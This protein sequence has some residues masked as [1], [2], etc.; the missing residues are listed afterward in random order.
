MLKFAELII[1][2]IISIYSG[3]FTHVTRAALATPSIH[4]NQGNPE[5]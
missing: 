1:N 5:F 3:K 4:G 2:I